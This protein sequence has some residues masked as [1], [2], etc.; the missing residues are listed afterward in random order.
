MELWPKGVG[1]TVLSVPE[2]PLGS[3][4]TEFNSQ[5]MFLNY[6]FTHCPHSWVQH[7]VVGLQDHANRSK[8]PELKEHPVL[9]E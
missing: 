1:S 9:L 7:M 5:W 8:L 6:Y 4:N 3:Q 2:R